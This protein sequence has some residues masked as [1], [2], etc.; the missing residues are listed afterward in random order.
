VTFYLA[1]HTA[2]NASTFAILFRDNWLI[3]SEMWFYLCRYTPDTAC[4]NLQ[5]S[6]GLSLHLTRSVVN[7]PVTNVAGNLPV[8]YSYRTRMLPV[9]YA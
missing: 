5:S 3:L 1:S 6:H 8:S 4:I 2:R 7:L 9:C